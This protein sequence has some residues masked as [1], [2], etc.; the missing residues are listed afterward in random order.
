MFSVTFRL[1][2]Q[3]IF[4]FFNEWFLLARTNS[5]VEATQRAITEKTQLVAFLMPH[6]RKDLYDRMKQLCCLQTPIPSQ[7][8]LTRY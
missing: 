2:P 4:F 7:G 6:Q 1:D 5:F 3:A 8:M